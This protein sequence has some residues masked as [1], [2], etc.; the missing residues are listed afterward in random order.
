MMTLLNKKELPSQGVKVERD[1]LE[2]E[3]E[4]VPDEEPEQPRQIFA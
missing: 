3:E 1:E 2:E 4:E